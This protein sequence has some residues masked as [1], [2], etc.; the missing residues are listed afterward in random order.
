MYV[1]MYV[2]MYIYTYIYL[3]IYLSLYMFIYVSESWPSCPLLLLECKLFVGAGRFHC[4][5]YED[6]RDHIEHCVSKNTPGGNPGQVY[7]PIPSKTSLEALVVSFR[8]G[9]SAPSL[10]R[11]VETLCTSS[12]DHDDANNA[13]ITS[14]ISDQ[15]RGTSSEKNYPLVLCHELLS[16][17]GND[18][19]HPHPAR[20][21][22][23]DEGQD[24]RICS[25]FG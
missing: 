22:T 18:C 1:C 10:D 20:Y 15:S 16:K 8:E 24:S 4:L 12:H 14:N 25:R 5:L 3:F 21:S 9:P 23:G 7:Q 2:C 17:H 19:L 11:T 6:R 13:S